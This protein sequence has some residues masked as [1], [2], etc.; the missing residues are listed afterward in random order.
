[1]T[2]K[3]KRTVSLKIY[4]ATI[5]ALLIIC[6]A[7]TSYVLSQVSD[8]GNFT[9]A[10]GVYPGGPSYTIWKDGS[11]YYAK[12]ANGQIDYS[13][14]NAS[15]IFLSAIAGM[16]DGETLFIKA[17]SYKIENKIVVN[18]CIILS[19]EG[20]GNTELYSTS[21]IDILEVTING[22]VIE[23]LQVDGWGSNSP[24]SGIYLHG[25]TAGGGGRAY[26]Y[27][28]YVTGIN[29]GIGIKIANATLFNIYSPVIVNCKIG[30]LID[31]QSNGG[32][33]FGGNIY[34]N[35][36][37]STLVEVNNGDTLHIYGT[38]LEGNQVYTTGILCSWVNSH[39]QL[40][41]L[42]FEFL[43]NG[44]K[45][46][47]GSYDE[48]YG[49][50]FASVTNRFVNAPSTTRVVAVGCQNTGV[51][52]ITSGTSVTFNHGLYGTPSL[53]LASFSSASITGWT[54]TATSTQ[55]TIIVTPSGTYTVYWYAEYK[56]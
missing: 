27:N 52:T 24:I 5:T 46:I 30:I 19:G 51:A 17:G 54:W 23:N 7:T 35:V 25:L 12:N 43:L 34:S 11:T 55:I 44:I 53:V 3:L 31:S 6:F 29:N 47:N 8:G 2:L 36:V 22:V 45:W 48:I 49:A 33:I 40:S 56:P 13:G 39:M 21:A 37:N 1:V 41:N 32:N 42:R 4:L 14:T 9:I 10:P 20:E 26:L 28:V 38:D 50:S 16:S 15:Q 18:K